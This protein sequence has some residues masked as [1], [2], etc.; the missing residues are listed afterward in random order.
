MAEVSRG[1]T[2]EAFWRRMVQAQTDSGLSIRAWCRD[3]DLKDTTF[4]WWRREL[5]RRA[6]SSPAFPSQRPTSRGHQPPTLRVRKPPSRDS[7]KTAV[8][9]SSRQ[10]QR[11]TTVALPKRAE[12]IDSS[13]SFV[14][15]HVAKDHA[16]A[17]DRGSQIE[18]TWPDGRSVRVTGMVDRQALADVLDV[19]AGQLC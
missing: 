3:Q 1:V 9:P 2:K 15:V 8:K 18:I 19:L 14:P 13:P 16:G 5:T 11:A 7:A 6:S 12:P 4:Y 17:G 10:G